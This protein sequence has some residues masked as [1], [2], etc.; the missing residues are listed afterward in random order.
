MSTDS[1]IELTEP[2]RLI[3][4]FIHSN[5]SIHRH[6]DISLP[7][8]GYC[9]LMGR[10]AWLAMTHHG[11]KIEPPQ[12]VPKREWVVG[13]LYDSGASRVVLI[14][15]NRPEW[16]AGKL[17]GVGGKVEV[18]ESTLYAMVR[19]FMEETGVILSSWS[20]FASLRWEEGVV[21]FFRTFEPGS[22]LDKCRTTTDEEI[23]SL[24]IENLYIPESRVTTIPNLLWLIPLG[25]HRHDTYDVIDVIEQDT[26]LRKPGR[27]DILPGSPLVPLEPV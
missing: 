27:L 11:Y 16:Q 1:H 23:V 6:Y 24:P 22:V 18:G 8:C 20:E 17:N 19:E 15:K 7:S 13:F 26:T 2:E 4:E 3:A 9:D 10:Y 25:A 21:H 5:D 14:R 12:V